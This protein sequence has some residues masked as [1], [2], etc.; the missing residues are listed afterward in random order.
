[1]GDIT[2]FVPEKSLTVKRIFEEYKKVGDSE[3]TRGYLGASIIGHPCERYLWYYFRQCCK[4]SFSGRMYRLFETGDLAEFRFTKNLR[5][6]KCEV[7]DTDANGEQFEVL[8]L[9]GHFSGHMDG[10][11]LGV[12]EAPK[13][14]HVLEF[15][16]NNAK[17]FRKLEKNGVQKS[18]PL[19]YAQM[20]V[21]MHLT[22]MTRA[23]YLASNKDTDD[24]YSER[25]RYDKVFADNLMQKAERVIKAS[26]PPERAFNRRDYYEC[27]WCDAQS[28]CW[29]PVSPEPALPVSSLSCRQCCHATPLLGTS[30]SRA[31]WECSL[32]AKS[33]DAPCK[34]HLCLPGLFSFAK[35]EGYEKNLEGYES[36]VFKNEDGTSW[37][38][39]NA[40]NCFRSEELMKLPANQLANPIVGSIKKLF[41]AEVTDCQ[42]DILARYPKEDI[43]TLWEGRESEIV[44][45][46]MEVF[47]EDLNKLEPIATC[48]FSDYSVAEVSGGRIAIVWHFRKKAEIRRSKE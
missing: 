19:H 13:T 23:L 14:W 39:G 37:R 21:Y 25:I 18:K 44:Q 1:M 48:S 5:D 33:A 24:L 16:T 32:L 30:D 45:A 36:I 43:E 29:G 38:H 12:P 20:Q 9:G 8:A 3:S 17:S 46:W 4:S 26:S 41:K 40:D 35:P 42:N 11:A 27:G 47:H 7:H 28:I 31:A 15:K 34:C 22:G 10:C 2:K 6:I